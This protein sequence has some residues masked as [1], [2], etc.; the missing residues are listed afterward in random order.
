MFRAC[1]F[2]LALLA[3]AIAVSL[4]SCAKSGSS[5]AEQIP[6]HEAGKPPDIWKGGKSSLLVLAGQDFP[7]ESGI[8][9]LVSWEYGLSEEKGR[10]RFL[11]WPRTFEEQDA[12]LRLLSNTA[13]EESPEIIVAIGAPRGTLRELNRIRA[14]FPEVKIVSIFPIDEALSIEAVSDMVIDMDIFDAQASGLDGEIVAEDE[15]ALEISGREA[16]MLLLGAVFSM[17]KEKEAEAGAPLELSAVLL[18]AN[19]DIAEAVAMQADL[20]FSAPLWEYSQAVD[21][22]TGLRSRKHVLIKESENAEKK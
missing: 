11:Y 19:M 18:K 4:A 6:R 17:E 14:E 20:D 7:E 22:E 8:A 16:A 15:S 2:R 9:S 12:S 3:A 13:R 1:I 21:A 5:A 10:A